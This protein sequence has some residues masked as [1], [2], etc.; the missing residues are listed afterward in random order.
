MKVESNHIKIK[1]TDPSGIDAEIFNKYKSHCNQMMI[2]KEDILEKYPTSTYAGWALVSY[3]PS[4]SLSINPE[5][6]LEEAM[7]IKTNRI[8][9]HCSTHVIYDKEGNAKIMYADEIAS[10]YAEKA[11]IFLEA[12]PDF[13]YAGPIYAR[14]GTSLVI[15]NRWQEAKI[16]YENALKAS[17]G[18]TIEIAKRK[19][20]IKK[21]IEL[22]LEKKLAKE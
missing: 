19:M 18:N 21:I 22:L 3:L 7:D 17:W 14:L 2:Y 9:N 16:A 10:K 13:Y 12:H 8:L 4:L 11:K 15:L 20:Q 6:L 1:L 5:L